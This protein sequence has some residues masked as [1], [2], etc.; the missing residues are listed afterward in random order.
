MTAAEIFQ[1]ERNL[2]V[3]DKPT[4]KTLGQRNTIRGLW[5]VLF[6]WLVVALMVG[7][8]IRYPNPFLYVLCVFVIGARMMGMWVLLHEGSHCS[9]TKHR[10]LNDTVSKLFLAWPIFLSF[11]YFKDTHLAHHK[12]LKSEKDPEVMLTKFDEFRFPLKK[13]RLFIVLLKDFLGINFLIYSIR[14]L[15]EFVQPNESGKG[16]FS[17]LVDFLKSVSP[18]RFVYYAAIIAA[19]IYFGVFHYFL[20]FWIVPYLTWYQVVFR[21]RLISDHFFADEPADYPTRTVMVSLFERIFVVPHNYVNFHTEHHL[22]SGIPGYKLSK[23]HNELFKNDYYK[24]NSILVQGYW[25]VLRQ[26]VN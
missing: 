19:T 2:T 23:T 17:K 5:P 21:I 7:V 8:C 18:V 16:F 4:R 1:A 6:D 20:L 25:T 15:W 22:Y 3:L 11:K 10:K 9:L 14:G 24:N 13:D 12:Y 26:L